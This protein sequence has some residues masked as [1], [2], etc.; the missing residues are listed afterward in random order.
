MGKVIMVCSGKG[1]VGKTTVSANLGAALTLENKSVL[2]VDNDIGL[3][4]LDLA[5]GLEN[6]VFYDIIDV[7]NDDCKIREAVIKDKNLKSLSM[8]PASQFKEGCCIDAVKYKSV[9]SKVRDLYDFVIIDCPAGIGENVTNCIDVADCAL[10]VVNSD[11]YSLRDADRIID[12]IS[13]RINDVRIIVNRIRPSL[14]NKG[15]TLNADSIIES[16]GTRLVGLIT[17]DEKI[18]ESSV[19]G[20]PYV[21]TAKKNKKNEFLNIAGRLC[22][23]N[24]PIKEIRKPRCFFRKG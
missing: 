4:N 8:L 2:L 21:L 22:G 9:I 18:I 6:N 24:I 23:E 14:V 5:L 13:D 16:L 12:I 11:P 3:R 7:I 10:V 15:I 20:I 17:E 19:T 1:G